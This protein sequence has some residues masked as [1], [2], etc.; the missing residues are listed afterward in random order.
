MQ[1]NDAL[2][3]AGF[4][5]QDG[6]LTPDPRK[7]SGKYIVA[8][9]SDYPT[10]PPM[11]KEVL[12]KLR[13]N[14]DRDALNAWVWPPRG[15]YGIWDDHAR[16][17][18]SVYERRASRY[19]IKIPQDLVN[20]YGISDGESLER[21]ICE[22]QIVLLGPTSIDVEP[23]GRFNQLQTPMLESPTGILRLYVLYRGI[24][25]R[26]SRDKGSGFKGP[27]SYRQPYL[28][29][30]VVWSPMF[31][32]TGSQS[33]DDLPF[34]RPRVQ[35][36]VAHFGFTQLRAVDYDSGIDNHVRKP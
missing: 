17:F 14:Y 8:T 6:L 3:P 24:A 19:G 21:A 13:S 28:Y 26:L 7:G 30:V 20:K 1:L 25:H 9:P 36:A 33:L 22:G 35:S 15:E 34:A 5:I 10:A 2:I 4:F 23:S 12:D 18:S 27:N 16:R 32:V 11:R 29:Q 31:F